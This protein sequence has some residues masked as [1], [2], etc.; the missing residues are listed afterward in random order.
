MTREEANAITE[1][2]DDDGNLKDEI[3]EEFKERYGEDD[4][5]LDN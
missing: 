5:E 4:Q 1:D 2:D 3:R